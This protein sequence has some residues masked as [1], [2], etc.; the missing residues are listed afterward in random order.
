[1]QGADEAGRLVGTSRYGGV[2]R[3][4]PERV[5][6]PARRLA[7]GELRYVNRTA[8]LVESCDGGL[9]CHLL[10]LDLRTGAL[11]AATAGGSEL[12]R[13]A[14]SADGRHLAGVAEGAVVVDDLVG[15]SRSLLG[16]AGP[17]LWF[18][19][20]AD[21]RVLLVGDGTRIH[22]VDGARPSPQDAPFV[23]LDVLGPVVRG[24][25]GPAG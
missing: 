12:A 24:V 15:G 25:V 1:V 18:S 16:E 23:D 19:W 14:L 17:S 2:Y 6:S 8:G 3:I 21:G 10:R 13:A 7:G 20:T 11:S 22:R 9:A 4:E 5:G